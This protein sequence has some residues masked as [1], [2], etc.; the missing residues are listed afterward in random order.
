[1]SNQAIQSLT[2]ECSAKLSKTQAQNAK[3]K[4][5]SLLCLL[6]MPYLNC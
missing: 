6:L 2:R 1:M 5:C 4:V 3:E